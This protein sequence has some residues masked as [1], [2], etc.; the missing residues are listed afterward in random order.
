[1]KSTGTSRREFLKMTAAT[2]V[3]A[4]TSGNLA[5]ATQVSPNDRI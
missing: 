5:G 1:M 2:G 3:A 4:G